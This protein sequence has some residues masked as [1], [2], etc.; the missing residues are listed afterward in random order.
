[1]IALTALVGRRDRRR[2][3]L[4]WDLVDPA[5]GADAGGRYQPARAGRRAVGVAP[6]RRAPAPA[7][8]ARCRSG[9]W[10]SAPARQPTRSCARCWPRPTS[11]YVPVAL[12]DDDRAKRNLRISGVRVAG[13][14]DDLCRCRRAVPRRRAVLIAVPSAD[15]CVHPPCRRV[16]RALRTRRC[17]CCRRSRTCSGAVGR[18]RHPP[19]HRMPTCSVAIRPRSIR[20]RSPGTSPVGGCWSPAPAGRSAASCAARSCASSR[21]R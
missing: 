21:R 7:E 18:G 20:S 13:T 9:S 10:W 5:F 11:P 4:W 16:G 19:G 3:R 6:V 12:L 17:S 14:V 1:M 15:S 2:W 8:R